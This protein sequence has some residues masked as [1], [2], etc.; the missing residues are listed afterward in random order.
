V[1]RPHPLPVHDRPL[2]GLLGL[3]ATASLSQLRFGY[4]RA[5]AQ[6]TRSGDHA[7][8]LA[9][10]RAFDDLSRSTRRQIYPTTV[11]HSRARP[12]TPARNSRTPLRRP[13]PR[14]RRGPVARRRRVLTFVLTVPAVAAVVALALNVGALG[15]HRDRPAAPATRPVD[16]VE[17]APAAVT[18]LPARIVPPN[19]PVDPQGYVM[20]VCQD[21]GG[22]SGTVRF[23]RPGAVVTCASGAM[24]RIVADH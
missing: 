8:A 10:S 16:Q 13:T 7:R 4:E 11:E 17:P 3:P 6:A 5:M 21:L 15:P 20:V 2:Y 1:A 12:A 14:R 23:V 24:P 22:G 18:D 9:L 19:T